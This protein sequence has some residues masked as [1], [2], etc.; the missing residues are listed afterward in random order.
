MSEITET[1]E[2][3]KGIKWAQENRAQLAELFTDADVATPE[4][5]TR[6]F[7]EAA[8]WWPSHPGDLQNDLRQTAF[9]AGALKSVINT[10]PLT[11]E[12]LAATMDAAMEMGMIWG[13]EQA[14]VRDLEALRK[15][16]RGWWQR[17]FGDATP[18]QIVGAL[19]IAWRY[20]RR[21]DSKES[22]PKNRWQVII[23]QLGSRETGVLNTLEN[24][25]QK[26]DGAYI[27]WLVE[28]RE[29]TFEI[30]ARPVYDGWRMVRYPG[31]IV[32]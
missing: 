14:K 22:N 8:N 31:E 32:G 13:A 23:D 25:E 30:L 11:Q 27:T 10:L 24:I 18:N 1:P 29:G 16:P 21:R 15:K 5:R 20:E 6:L 9:V 12:A 3:H 26:G 2:Y 28:G 4:I 17:K 19:S 7:R